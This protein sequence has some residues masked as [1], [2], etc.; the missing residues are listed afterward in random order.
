MEKLIIAVGLNEN[1]TRDQNPHVPIT[2]DEIARDVAACQEAGASIVHLHARD[3]RTGAPRM[4]DPETYLEIFR[5]IRKLADIPCYPTYP[6]H[7]DARERYRHVVAIAEDPDCRLEIAP[8]IAGTTNLAYYDARARRLLSPDLDQTVLFN[9]YSYILHHLEFA[10]KHDLWVSHD[11]F[12]PGMVR[13]AITLWE[14]GQYQRPMLL[15]F[16]MADCF[17]FG[18]PPEQRYLQT[19]AQMIPPQLDCEWLFLPYGVDYKRCLE[20]WTWCIDHGGHV[21]VGVGDNPAGPGF[22]PT[23]AERVREMVE[24][25]LSRGREVATVDDVRRRFAR[26]PG[27]R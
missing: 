4:N 6:T 25:A 9:P 2:P 7:V 15:K 22:L 16:F 5:A 13:N 26:L 21:R 1:V 14:M 18:F 24:L 19:Y 17:S 12:E 27:A 11:V 8:C 23:N 3:P 20:L 10:R